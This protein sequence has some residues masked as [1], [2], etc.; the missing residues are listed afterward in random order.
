MLDYI[1]PE[2][3]G[4]SLTVNDHIDIYCKKCKKYFTK[5]IMKHLSGQG[6]PHC[7][8]DRMSSYFR[9]S[10][11]EHII[12]FID[13]HGDKYIYIKSDITN[14]NDKILIFCKEHQELFYQTISGHKSGTGCIKCTAEQRSKSRTISQEEYLKRVHE[15]HGE[16]FN[17][18]RL[19]YTGCK[20]PIIV[21][22]KLHN[23]FFEIDPY[24]FLHCKF[25]CPECVKEA[26]RK[27]CQMGDIEFIRQAKELYEDFYDY[28]KVIYINCDTPVII[29][30]PIHGEF[31]VTP[32]SHLHGQQCGKCKN[33]SKMEFFTQL[34]LEKHNFNFK[35][36]QTF[37]KCKNKNRLRFD[38]YLPNK[39]LL[40][41]LDGRQHFFPVEWFGGI[42]A[43]VKQQK[44]DLIKELYC[45]Q[46]DIELLRIP[47]WDRDNI[48]EILTNKLINNKV[49]I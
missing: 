38:F 48:E 33:K 43:F 39:N 12:D 19:F 30:C 49:T 16:K 23:I 13:I 22:C 41:E 34:F 32:Y 37:N 3:W 2:D 18:T 28:S 21:G 1:Y 36:Q 9:K 29:I 27:L 15:A 20:D 4:N 31:E 26:Q 45:I 42:K 17:L 8:L 25:A 10:F 47:Y 24:V 11:E 35:V 6:C 40:I 46:H 14:V 5:K 44:R 7:S